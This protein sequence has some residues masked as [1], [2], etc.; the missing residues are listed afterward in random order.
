MAKNEEKTLLWRMVRET[1]SM[2][3][4][5]SCSLQEL[6]TSIEKNG[7]VGATCNPVIVLMVLK[8]EWQQWRD[9][10]PQMIRESPCAAD[11]EIAWTLVEEMSIKA[12]ELL[13]PVFDREKGR[14]G[15]LCI[16]TNPKYFRN[17][18][19]IV[20]QAEHFAGLAPNIMVKIPATRAGIEAIEEATWR[21]VSINSTVSFTVPQVV[22]AAEAVERGLKR[23]EKEG[24]SVASMGPVCTLMVGRL[25]DWL[26]TLAEKKNIIA[27]PCAQSGQESQS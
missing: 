5:D 15:R 23:R 16:Q 17:A 8:Q 1:P 20:A 21:G 9:R 13:A 6:K 18:A 7:A 19:A 26:K 3:W 14:S 2:L 27:N 12:A 4:N 10:I 22:A 11:A 25:D 24:K